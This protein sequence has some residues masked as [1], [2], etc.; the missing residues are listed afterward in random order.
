METNHTNSFSDLENLIRNL[1]IE[2]TRTLKIIYGIQKMQWAVVL[3]YILL[4]NWFIYLNVS[5][6][7]ILGAI[8]LLIAFVGYG[9]RSG[10]LRKKLEVTDYGVPTIEMLEKVAHRYRFQIFHKGAKFDVALFILVDTGLCF[11]LYSNPFFGILFIQVFFVI[12]FAFSF[13]IG[14]L[15]WEK[16]QKPLRDRALDLLKE[17][18]S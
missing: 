8:I 2:D 18:E 14:Y 17:I 7:K 13:L 15:I 16:R 12:A 4:L 5:W 1:K 10:I 6:Y 3:I 9:F 11:M